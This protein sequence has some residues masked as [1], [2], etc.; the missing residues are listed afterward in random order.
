MIFTFTGLTEKESYHITQQVYRMPCQRK[1]PYFLAAFSECYQSLIL[2][3]CITK[4]HYIFNVSL[5]LQWI[6]WTKI[7]KNTLKH[8]MKLKYSL[9]IPNQISVDKLWWHKEWFPARKASARM[10]G[11]VDPAFILIPLWHQSFFLAGRQLFRIFH[12]QEIKVLLMVLW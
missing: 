6:H 9:Y 10:Y 12:Q 1:V 5:P 4:K 2:L 3:K 7:L 11:D 8:I